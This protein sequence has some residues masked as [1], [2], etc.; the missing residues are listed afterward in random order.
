M[1]TASSPSLESRPL[2]RRASLSSKGSGV[3]RLSR[4]IHRL[5]PLRKDLC[6]KPRLLTVHVQPR[7]KLLLGITRILIFL[8][9]YALAQDATRMR[10][11]FTANGSSVSNGNK[12]I[13]TSWHMHW[14]LNFWHHRVMNEHHLQYLDDRG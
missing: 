1:K 12:L 9:S 8:I 2:L 6:Q 11:I 10:K 7:P 5:G 13:T 14:L 3:C 4:A